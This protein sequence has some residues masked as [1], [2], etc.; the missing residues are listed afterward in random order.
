MINVHEN[1]KSSTIWSMQDWQSVAYFFSKLL[2]E[3]GVEIKLINKVSSLKVYESSLILKCVCFKMLIPKSVIFFINKKLYCT[4]ELLFPFI[5][6]GWTLGSFCPLPKCK[7]LVCTDKILVSPPGFRQSYKIPSGY[8]TDLFRYIWHRRE[9][10]LLWE[11]SLDIKK[12]VY[13]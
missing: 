3:F 6:L 13:Y 9:I 5:P 1:D 7:T 8:R 10:R 11:A 12:R 2:L 4:L